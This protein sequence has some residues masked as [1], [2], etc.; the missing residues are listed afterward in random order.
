MILTAPD[1]TKKISD[2][3]INQIRDA[4]MSGQ[5][6]IGDKIGSEKDLLSQLNV[7]KATLRE[8]LRV[9]ETMGM[10][11][12]R[13]GL[14]GGVFV[15]EVD[16]KATLVSILNFLN[17]QAVSIRDITMVRYIL[18]PAIVQLAAP[19][20]NEED[21]RKIKEM[22]KSESEG[23]ET[24]DPIKG[25]SFH[26]YLARM[27]NN[28]ILILI[29]DFIDN[30][31]ADI[32]IKENLGAD[33]YEAVTVYH[34][35]ILDCI[36]RR[37]IAEAIRLIKEDIL[38]VGRY[39]AQ[40]SNSP[41]FEPSGSLRDQVPD[42]PEMPVVNGAEAR[43]GKSGPQKDLPLAAA[44]GG[45]A[46]GSPSPGKMLMKQVGSGKLYLF[47]FDETASSDQ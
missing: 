27:T 26:R 25:I 3:I 46:A 37:D 2:S 45:L 21:V 4:V 42:V 28:P 6:K 44:A 36:H 29:M 31:V 23:L 32:K 11:E 38:F 7:S 43:G 12:I 5:Y 30:L 33:F 16:M 10:V 20:I 47:E 35:R 34:N 18:E 13:K 9:L 8:A 15:A 14:S 17:F 1:R 22:I 39:L 41:S 24:T 40:R 19:L